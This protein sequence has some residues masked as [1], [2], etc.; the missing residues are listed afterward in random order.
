[1]N[2][3]PVPGN[4]ILLS[5]AT[6]VLAVE[7]L[8]GVRIPDPVDPGQAITEGPGFC[9]ELDVPDRDGRL[10][11]SFGLLGVDNPAAA[12]V[13]VQARQHDDLTLLHEWWDLDVELEAYELPWWSARIPI[14][15]RRNTMVRW[16]S[17]RWVLRLVDPLYRHVDLPAR[18]SLHRLL[19]DWRDTDA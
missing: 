17:S 15:E 2:E 14:G 11:L 9:V 7:R 19:P 18:R 4:A 8:A 16:A 6:R 12:A 10:L 3:Y 1:V 13:A 5:A